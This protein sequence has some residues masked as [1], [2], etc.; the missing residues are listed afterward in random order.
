[1]KTIDKIRKNIKRKYT[2]VSIFYIVLIL[3]IIGVCCIGTFNDKTYT[4]TVT[5]KERVIENNKE[6]TSKYLIYGENQN[7][8]YVFENTDNWLRGKF[9]SSDF[10]G[11]IKEGKTYKFTVIGYRIPFFSEYE[12][13]IKIEEV[14]D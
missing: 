12:N 1:M 3:I 2:I 8:T 10:Y 6:K 5:D 11:K 13:I 14:K 4:V 9:N 7:E